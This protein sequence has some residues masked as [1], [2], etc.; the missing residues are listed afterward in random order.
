MGEKLYELIMSIAF[1]IEGKNLGERIS[2]VNDFL[3][4][5]REIL[6]NVQIRE[7]DLFIRA[8]IVDEFNSDLIRPNALLCS[9]QIR[10]TITDAEEGWSDRKNNMVFPLIAKTLKALEHRNDVQDLDLKVERFALQGARK[11][12]LWPTEKIPTIGM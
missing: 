9:Q 7:G 5:F 10:W 6:E 12:G 8:A 4:K 3:R 1:K 2:Q 11:T